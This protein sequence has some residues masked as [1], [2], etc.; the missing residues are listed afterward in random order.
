[1]EGGDPVP[2][3]ARIVFLLLRVTSLHVLHR[4]RP[5][6]RLASDSPR[7][8]QA[9]LHPH[10]HDGV[11]APRAAG[12]YLHQGLDS[13]P[14][15]AVAV[16]APADLPGSLL[17]DRALR[18]EGEG[19]CGSSGDLRGDPR[20]AARLSSALVP[21]KADRRAAADGPAIGSLIGRLP[22]HLPFWSRPPAP[23]GTGLAHSPPES[24]SSPKVPD[25]RTTC[26]LFW[27]H[28]QAD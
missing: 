28:A 22:R 9:A 11:S 14:R 3:H 2:A 16:T 4:A 25:F 13:A 21:P 5:V 19:N 1:M 7:H 27:P 18:V 8:S 12:S 23:P 17:C 24:A 26:S 15:T 10:G 20:R 6:L